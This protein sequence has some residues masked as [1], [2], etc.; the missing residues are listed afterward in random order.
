MVCYFEQS[1][2]LIND[3]LYGG[4]DCSQLAGK[5]KAPARKSQTF[6]NFKFE[7]IFFF[8]VGPPSGV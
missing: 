3:T 5:Q 2:T 1:G 8:T 4:S 7:I 6:Q